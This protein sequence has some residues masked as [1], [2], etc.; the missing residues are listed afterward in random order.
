LPNAS[1]YRILANLA[2][3]LVRPDGYLGHVRPADDARDAESL[4]PEPLLST[5]Q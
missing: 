1:N 4:P 2:S 5:A 3:V